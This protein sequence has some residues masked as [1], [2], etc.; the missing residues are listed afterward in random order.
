MSGDHNMYCSANQPVAWMSQG[1]DVTRSKDYF[2]EMGFKDL[3]PLYTE[4]Q[5]KDKCP[6]CEYNKGRAKLWRDAAYA[7]PPL[8][9]LSDEE[10]L[11]LWSALPESKVYES[12]LI[13]FAKAVLKEAR[14]EE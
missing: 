14:G 13:R 9:E 11:K 4:P 10:I 5:P 2:E 6:S 12:D 1:G 3:I 7:N 8:K